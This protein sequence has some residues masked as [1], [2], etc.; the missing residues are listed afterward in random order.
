MPFFLL[1]LRPFMKIGYI[2]PDSLVLPMDCADMICAT[3]ANDASTQ[4]YF[5]DDEGNFFSGQ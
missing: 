3:S 2:N 4:D 1:F 5:M